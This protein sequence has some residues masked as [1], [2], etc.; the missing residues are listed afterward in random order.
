MSNNTVS[1]TPASLIRF[2]AAYNS[3]EK[4]TPFQFNGNLFV[5]D[6]ARYLIEYAAGQLGMKFQIE[7]E[8]GKISVR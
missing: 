6:Y 3:S 5:P 2:T 8:T 1:F 7:P 4:H